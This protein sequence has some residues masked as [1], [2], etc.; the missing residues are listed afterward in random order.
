MRRI[1]EV[2]EGSLAHRRGLVPGDMVL[3]INDEPLMDEI[4]YQAL[5]ATRYVRMQ[6][7]NTEGIEREVDFVKSSG[8]ALGIQFEDSLFCNPKTCGN[9][10]LFCFVDQ[11]PPGLRQ[12]LYLKDDDWRMSL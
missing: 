2:K 11:L 5:T 4:D 10:C 6:V 12:S 8:Q 3:S 7:K 1:S 9:H